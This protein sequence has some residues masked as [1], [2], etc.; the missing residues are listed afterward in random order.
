MC[1]G[2]NLSVRTCDDQHLCL[3]A[4]T[5]FTQDGN[6]FLPCG[7]TYHLGCIVVSEPFRSR[8]P[9]GKGLIFPKLAVCPNFICELCTVRAHLGRELRNTGQDTSLL[10]LERM[11]MIDQASAW[12][13]A[14]LQGYQLHLKRLRRFEQKH[15]V[16]ALPSTPLTSP[17]VSPAIPI[18]WAQQ[19][20][21][22]ETP[23]RSHP[24]SGDRISYG[25]ARALRSAAS[26]FFTYD[27]QV[28]YPGQAM[29]D[30][31][32]RGHLTLGCLPTDEL[33]Y[34]LMTT[35][36]A[37]RL[38]DSSRPCMALNFSQVKRIDDFLE[39]CFIGPLSIERKR[40][41][42]AAGAA[43][44][45][46]WTTWCRSNELFSRNWED[47][48]I[49]HPKDHLQKG[50]AEG[51]G[52]IELLL[53]EETKSNRTSIA[54][55]IV[56]YESLVTKLSWGK[57][58]DRLRALWP[59]HVEGDVPIIRGS[60]GKRWTSKSFRYNYVYPW[61]EMLKQEGDPTLVAF[62]NDEGNRIPDKFYSM[63]MYRRGGRSESTKRRRG[64][65]RATE[66]EVY[67]HGRW[68][69]KRQLENMPT[70]YREF[71]REDRVYITLLCM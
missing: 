15:G 41:I 58:L 13:P 30:A 10:M 68:L 6:V 59:D 50:L 1:V 52:M 66:T 21:T 67:E 5:G 33:G 4:S 71:T 8:L 53:L 3:F 56:A 28:S 29:R 60:D 49:T 62:N 18:M 63:N 42:A 35:G 45:G 16:S 20:Y 69:M 11:R 24:T 25:T 22:L 23:R 2:C 36:M 34:T 55:V 57:W 17:P 40:D 61:L 64:K 70:R 54:D 38:G 44:L 14:T 26:A 32:R 31:Q 7:T 9:A 37:R 43:H 51:V 48:T 12:D 27:L 47:V 19:Q 46:F 39:Q 65:K